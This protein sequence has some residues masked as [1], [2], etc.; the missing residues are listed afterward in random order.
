MD[1]LKLNCFSLCIGQEDNDDGYR[2]IRAEGEYDGETNEKGQKHGHGRYLFSNGDSYD[3]EWKRDKMHGFGEYRSA[4]GEIYRGSFKKGKRVQ[5]QQS[6]NQ[7]TLREH[8]LPQ[9][10]NR[11]P[12]QGKRQGSLDAF[13]G[14]ARS[15]SEKV[16]GENQPRQGK[17]PGSLDAFAEAARRLSENV[18]RKK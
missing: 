1:K 5:S 6:Q 11:Q 10:E 14:S 8:L 15:L 18:A 3:G 12:R 7:T 16:T 4:S 17:R 9:D 13:A 2:I